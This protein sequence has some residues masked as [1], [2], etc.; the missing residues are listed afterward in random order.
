MIVYGMLSGEPIPVHSG[1]LL[2]R[3]LTLRGFW[4][5]HWFQATPPAHTVAV[6]SELM[7]LMARGQPSAAGGGRV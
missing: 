1:E 5:T 4:L 3:G 7:Q 6:L 2:F